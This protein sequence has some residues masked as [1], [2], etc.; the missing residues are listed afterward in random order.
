MMN[1]LKNALANVDP[2]VMIGAGIMLLSVGL[3][4]FAETLRQLQSDAEET[5]ATLSQA[6]S[7]NKPQVITEAVTSDQADS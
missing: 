1:R 5:M 7:M 3:N 2:L 6:A 4:G